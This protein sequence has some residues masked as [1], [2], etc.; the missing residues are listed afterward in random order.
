MP[1]V[2]ATMRPNAGDRDLWSHLF[3][4]CRHIVPAALN[5]DEGRLTPGS[6]EFDPRRVE[7]E[8]I[9]TV[10]VLIDIEAYH[11]RD[12]ENLEERAENIK[13]ALKVIFPDLT[14]AVWLKLVKA[15]WASDSVDPEFDGDMS[16]E[17]AIERVFETVPRDLL[18]NK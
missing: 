9:L 4:A 10:D 16:M 15:G 5:S 2:R 6:I 12:R 14:F 3:H 13:R 8:G 17:A 11:Y 1:L 18:F 7:S